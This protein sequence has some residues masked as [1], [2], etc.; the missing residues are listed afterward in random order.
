MNLDGV[1]RWAHKYFGMLLAITTNRHGQFKSMSFY[2]KVCTDTGGAGKDQE[3][4]VS[5]YTYPDQSGCA[6]CPSLF[7][8][9]SLFY[10]GQLVTHEILPII[11]DCQ[12]GGDERTVSFCGKEE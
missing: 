3:R 1:D 6:E 7:T 9:F 2:G 4:C 12:K 11:R 5:I 8:T 10:D